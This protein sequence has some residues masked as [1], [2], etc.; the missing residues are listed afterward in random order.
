MTIGERLLLGLGA[1]LATLTLL[2]VAGVPL[3]APLAIGVMG[4]AA[5]GGVLAARAARGR[6]SAARTAGEGASPWRGRWSAAEGV[7][8]AVV[9]AVVAVAALRTTFYPVSAMDAHAYDGRARAIVAERTLDISWYD[10]PGIDGRSNLSYPPGYPLS[11]ALVYWLGG[12]HGRIVDIAW[13]SALLLVVFE[14]VARRRGRL[15]GLA[16]AFLV[17]AAPEFWRHASLGL[18]NLAATAAIGAATLAATDRARPWRSALLFGLATL[19][20]I[21]SA[22]PALLVGLALAAGRRRFADLV[23]ALPALVVAVGWQVPLGQWLNGSALSALRPS[24]LPDPALLA[25]AL[26]AALGNLVRPGLYGWCFLV[27]AGGLAVGLLRGRRPGAEVRCLAAL[28]VVEF[29]ALVALYQQI[30][31]AFGGGTGSYFANSLKRALFVLMPG[32]AVA[33]C[34]MLFQRSREESPA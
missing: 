16:A 15:A 17:A 4:A 29:L 1:V 11:L 12:A 34:L 27:F 18:T 23:I 31:P 21:D 22:L 30:D 9:V 3:T 6:A 32:A 24:L 10:L 8:A 13:L 28:V 20:R 14:F 19:L 7:L 33:G 25:R 26:G 5:V 2:G